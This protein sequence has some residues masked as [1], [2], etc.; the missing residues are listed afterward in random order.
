MSDERTPRLIYTEKIWRLTGD[1]TIA[2]APIAF[3]APHLIAISS[4]VSPPTIFILFR[5]GGAAVLAACRNRRSQHL[6]RNAA[7]RLLRQTSRQAPRRPPQ[8]I[9]AR[10]GNRHG[11]T[12]GTSTQCS[13]HIR[14]PLYAP[15]GSVPSS[16]GGFLF[17]APISL[18]KSP[19]HNIQQQ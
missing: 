13:H 14:Q 6:T 4:S 19:L 2:V 12:H 5:G 15:S 16:N 10:H 11:K 9:T 18:A 3:E 7:N 8:K 17:R 1:A